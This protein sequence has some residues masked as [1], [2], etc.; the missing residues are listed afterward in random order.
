M[1]AIDKISL[2]WLEDAQARV[3]GDRGFRKRGSIDAQVGVACGADTF[4]VSFDAFA[5]Q[6][7]RAIDKGDLR[8][9]DF[10][11]EMTAERW[12][13]F[14]AERRAG[15]G[16]TLLELDATDGVVHAANPRKRL[17]FLRVHTSVQA[18]FDAGVGRLSPVRE[19]ASSY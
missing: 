6:R 13:R 19:T 9:A 1:A 10:V 16:R 12:E 4:L 17:E 7:V 14:L 3:N 2:K 18:F 15:G 5:C 8:D 11:V